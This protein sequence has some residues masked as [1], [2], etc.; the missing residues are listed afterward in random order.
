M[1]S[2]AWTS[3][4]FSEQPGRLRIKIS[5][6]SMIYFLEIKVL[7]FKESSI[8][9]FKLEGLSWSLGGF[10]GTTVGRSKHSCYIVHAHAI[11]IDPIINCAQ[12]L[13]NFRSSMMAKRLKDITKQDLL[14]I[15]K[16]NKALRIKPIVKLIE[17]CSSY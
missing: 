17:E 2:A 3:S 6:F 4:S 16:D 12:Y 8:A 13:F 1:I 15:N 11:K 10:A 14:D 9:I 7:I 5:G